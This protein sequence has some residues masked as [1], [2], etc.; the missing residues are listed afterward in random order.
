M[1]SRH[2]PLSLET[3]L[4]GA[5]EQE[6]PESSI[7]H[8]DGQNCN[9]FTIALN[10]SFTI[11]YTSHAAAQSASDIAPFSS[12]QQVRAGKRVAGRRLPPGLDVEPQWP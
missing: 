6:L 2:F 9:A 8:W 4:L 7:P 1:R 5:Q 3:Q 11:T 10:Y 12:Q